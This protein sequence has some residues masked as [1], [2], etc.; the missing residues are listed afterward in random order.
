MTATVEKGKCSN[1]AARI[2]LEFGRLIAKVS[3][4]IRGL[5]MLRY[6]DGDDSVSAR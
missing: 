5:A 2:T 6:R 1:A 3:S 4:V